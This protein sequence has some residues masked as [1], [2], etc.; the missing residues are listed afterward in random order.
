MTKKAAKKKPAKAPAKKKP[1]KKKAT[2]FVIYDTWIDG[3]LPLDEVL[4]A[5][6]YKVG[7]ARWVITDENGA[8]HYWISKEGK[9]PPTLNKQLATTAGFI[10]NA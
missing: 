4:I 10:Q 8:P 6:G 9:R 7:S 2:P 1:I 3:G 5:D